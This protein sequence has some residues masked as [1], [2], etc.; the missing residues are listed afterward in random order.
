M[1]LP[2]GN[3]SNTKSKP[4][5]NANAY[6]PNDKVPM[7]VPDTAQTNGGAAESKLAASAAIVEAVYLHPNGTASLNNAKDH[8]EFVG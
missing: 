8:N 2:S 4:I 7:S 6:E 1:V 3:K 5:V